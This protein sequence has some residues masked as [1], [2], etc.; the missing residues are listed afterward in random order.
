MTQLTDK[1]YA[2]EVPEDLLLPE[3]C[4]E[5]SIGHML[6][7]GKGDD[8]LVIRHRERSCGSPIGKVTIDIPSGSYHFLFTTKTATEEDAKKVVEPQWMAQAGT[9]PSYPDFTGEWAGFLNQAVKSLQSLIRSK[10]LN[11]KSYALIEKQSSDDT[12]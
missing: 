7:R 3:Y 5:K 9:V 6:N 4:F 11:D 10:G 2:V 8:E 12:E 1:I